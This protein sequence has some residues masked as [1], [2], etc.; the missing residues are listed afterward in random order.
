MLKLENSYRAALSDHFY[1][2][3]KPTPVDNP[4]LICFNKELAESLNLSDEFSDLDFAKNVLSGNKILN[5]SNPIAQAYAG[6]Q[7]GQFT[8]LGDGRAILLG[9]HLVGDERYDIQLKGSGATK[10]S[11]RGDGRATLS[12]MLREYLMSEAMYHLGIKTTRSLAVVKSGEPVYREQ[13][14]EGAVLTRIAKSHIRVG[15]FEYARFYTDQLETFTKYVIERHDPDL[16]NHEDSVVAFLQKVMDRQIN[17]VVDWM[18]VGFIHGVMNTDNMSIA[19]E[20]IDYGPCAFMNAYHP[21]TVF[22][23]IDRNGRYAY[24]NQP[25][26]AHWNLAILANALLPLMDA[27]EKKAVAKAESVIQSYSNQYKERFYRMMRNKLGISQADN[28][29][30]QLVDNLLSMLAQHQVD[31]T[32]FFVSLRYQSIEEKLKESADF[33]A[34][35]PRWQ[36]AF[37]RSESNSEGFKLMDENNPL[38]IPRNHLVEEALSNAV[39]GNLSTFEQLLQKLSSPYTKQNI[40]EVPVGFDQRYQTFCGT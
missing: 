27:D 32:N 19:G 5:A 37:N 29:D 4:E 18:R 16:I 7:F 21:G 40:Q 34:W 13:A 1:A 35:F 9:E 23:S 26:I 39:D 25:H 2:D 33:K 24:G 17:L 6:H 10:Y 15:T 8:V 31:Y 38:I 36:E 28:S 22:S 12:S 14:N 20:T 3:Q 30:I 11:R